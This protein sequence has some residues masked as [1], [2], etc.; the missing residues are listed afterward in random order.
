MDVLTLAE[1]LSRALLVDSVEEEGNLERSKCGLDVLGD[2]RAISLFH[3]MLCVRKGAWG[4]R[5]GKKHCCAE[6]MC[7]LVFVHPYF[8]M[9]LARCT[10]CSS[11]C[12]TDYAKLVC[13]SRR[14]QKLDRKSQSP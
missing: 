2:V 4:L 3:R 11:R 7:A 10:R 13:C 12:Q 14:G 5:A 6:I 1:L 8:L 9:L